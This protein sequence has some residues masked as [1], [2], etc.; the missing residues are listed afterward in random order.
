VL[1]ISGYTERKLP[2][3][4]SF[5]MKPFSPDQLAVTVRSVLTARSEA[6]AS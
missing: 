1:Y 4:A 2:E 3:G 6:V 5:L